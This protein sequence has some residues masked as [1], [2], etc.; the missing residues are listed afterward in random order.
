MSR[1]SASS[2]GQQLDEQYRGQLARLS[3]VEVIV[4]GVDVDPEVIEFAIGVLRSA[5]VNVAAVVGDFPLSA[6]D[7][8]P[9]ARFIFVEEST[10]VPATNRPSAGR[11]WDVGVVVG[12]GGHG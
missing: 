2:G 8:S 6:I 11:D 9:D 12:C 7:Q 5:Q 3:T 1:N 10:G 4:A